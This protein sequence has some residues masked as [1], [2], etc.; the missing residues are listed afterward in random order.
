MS[1][2]DPDRTSALQERVERIRRIRRGE[3]QDGLTAEDWNGLCR[4]EP[5]EGLSRSPS[6]GA[7]EVPNRTLTREERL[8]LSPADEARLASAEYGRCG[9]SWPEY[10]RGV[11]GSSDYEFPEA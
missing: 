7:P 8:A 10:E 3:D 4:P 6:T 1:A 2:E 9:G 5:E 11:D